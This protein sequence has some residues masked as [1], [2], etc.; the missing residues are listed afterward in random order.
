M[1]K[2]EGLIMSWKALMDKE[3]IISTEIEEYLLNQ[4]FEFT[5]FEPK[6]TNTLPLQFMSTK[7]GQRCLRLTHSNKRDANIS[8]F[9]TNFDVYFEM[10][11]K[12]GN[13]ITSNRMAVQKHA[14]RVKDIDNLLDNLV[15]IRALQ[16]S[17]RG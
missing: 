11:D 1:S 16:I 12:E 3:P 17:S 13:Y 9:V 15:S 2:K 8:F 6:F 14:Y 4:G 5:T 10:E 7:L